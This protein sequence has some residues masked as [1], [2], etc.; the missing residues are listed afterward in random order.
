MRKKS[1]GYLV[2][3]RLLDIAM[4]LF[5][6]LFCVA[7]LWWWIFIINVFSTKG[8]PFFTAKR[9]GKSK[10]IFN[11]F[12]F[13]TMKYGAPIIPPYELTDEQRFSIE[14]SF[15]RFLRKTS[16]DE[17]LQF[18][19]V[20]FGQMSLVG[21]RPG[22][23]INE[24]ILTEARDSVLPSPYDVL[25]GI[26]GLSQVNLKRGHNVKEKAQLDSEYVKKISFL[27]DLKI[28]VKTLKCLGGK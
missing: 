26:T 8:H 15:G 24:D 19:N 21:P 2:I 23:T 9:L 12:K 4:S 5:L 7:F 16:L 10:K 28:M 14:T 3:K 25:P 22:A 6:I 11:M 13:R 17:T 27:L 20:L 1:R 18:L